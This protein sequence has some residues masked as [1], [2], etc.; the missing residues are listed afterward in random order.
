MSLTARLIAAAALV[1]CAAGC[2]AAPGEA[3]PPPVEFTQDMA[4]S[5]L[6]KI[7]S[8]VAENG[9]AGFCSR[10]VRGTETC[11]TLLDGALRSCLLPGGKPEV[12]RAA[13][14]PP[15][16]RSEGGWLLELHGRTMD[17]QPYVSE[18]FAVRPGNEAPLAA[19][20]VY[21]TG[22]GLDGSPFGPDNTKVPQNACPG[23]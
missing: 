19:F 1:S 7:V 9:V 6:A 21:W 20:G 12:K 17:G 14:I 2:T 4:E 8:G 3:E 23:K 16:D 5:T 11:A 18:F 10:H 13:R 15:K 22:L